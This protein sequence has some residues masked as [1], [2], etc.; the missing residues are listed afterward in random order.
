MLGKWILC[1]AGLLVPAPATAEN[2]RQGGKL[3]LTDGMTSVEGSAGGGL[4]TWAL[5]GGKETD[6]GIGVSAHSTLVRTGRFTLSAVGAKVG[7]FDRVELSY[8]RQVFDTR[9]AGAKLGLG[10]GYKLG[11]HVI[12]AKVKVVGDA[13]Y[14]EPWLPQISLGVQHKIADKGTL[15]R[16]LGARHTSGTDVFVSA[17]KLQLDTGFLMGV[18]ARLTRANQFGLLG[19]GGDQKRGMSMQVEG[20][21]GKLLTRRLL[22]GAEYRSKPDNLAFA[23]EQDAVDLFAAYAIHRNVGIT[24]GYADLGS[25]ATFSKQRGIYLSLQG[26]F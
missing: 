16:A 6:A 9:S 12:G 26:A 22:I 20:S 3:L 24:A 18:T 5:I 11:Q 7:L 19:F 8:G 10:R 17:T 23:K 13:V 25:I 1:F 14:D 21:V 15:L 2:L 4:A